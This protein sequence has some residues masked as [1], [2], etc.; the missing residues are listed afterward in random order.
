MSNPIDSPATGIEP[1]REAALTIAAMAL[2]HAFR[3]RYVDLAAAARRRGDCSSQMLVYLGV[4][5]FIDFARLARGDLSSINVPRR[6]PRTGEHG[7][8]SWYELLEIVKELRRTS[9]GRLAMDSA[10]LGGTGLRDIVDD[11][12]AEAIRASFGGAEH[13]G[14]SRPA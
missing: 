7:P 13:R 4:R 10:R 12:D 11:R 14:G 2:E 1:V 9:D 5:L 8:E 3:M 6:L